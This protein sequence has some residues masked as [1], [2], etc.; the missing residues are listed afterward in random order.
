MVQVMV[1]GVSTCPLLMQ[2]THQQHPW[3]RLI[4]GVQS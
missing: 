4:T 2:P 3:S 1:G